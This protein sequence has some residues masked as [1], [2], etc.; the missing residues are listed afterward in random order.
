MYIYAYIYIMDIV[1]AF[2]QICENIYYIA[3][4]DIQWVLWK[5]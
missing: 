2:A 1:I 4:M 3:S 5:K